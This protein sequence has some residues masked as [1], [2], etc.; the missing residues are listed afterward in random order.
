MIIFLSFK[1]VSYVINSV[2]SAISYPLARMYELKSSHI[3]LM[4]PG[5]PKQQ[6]FFCITMKKNQLLIYQICMCALVFSTLLILFVWLYYNV[7]KIVWRHRKPVSQYSSSTLEMSSSSTSELTT[8]TMKRKNVNVERKIRTFKIIIT[9]VIVFILCRAPYWIVS[10]CKL[11]DFFLERDNW[12]MLYSFNGLALLNCALN[13]F[14]YTFLQ[15]TLQSISRVQN[16]ITDFVS[17]ICCCCISNTEFEEFET[18][19]AFV[20]W[21]RIKKYSETRSSNLNRKDTY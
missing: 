21:K 18:G 8:V 16:A 17:R 1:V 13:P 3:E 11:M 7:A 2:F 14:L 4:L 10:I 20:I 19:N 5:Q 6:M 15:F 9:L 12:V